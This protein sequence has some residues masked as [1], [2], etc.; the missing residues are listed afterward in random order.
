MFT[1]GLRLSHDDV[2]ND[3]LLDER[4]ITAFRVAAARANYLA[5]DRLDCQD[6]A[7]EICRHMAAPTRSARMALKGLYRYLVGLPR[8]VFSYK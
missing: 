5:A 3:Q 1:T 7:K 8:M 4:L 2:I 6:V